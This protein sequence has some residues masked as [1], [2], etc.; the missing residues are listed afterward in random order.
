MGRWDALFFGGLTIFALFFGF[1]SI[2]KW[3]KNRNHWS[4]LVA[5]MLSFLAGLWV[6]LTGAFDLYLGTMSAAL[7][8][9]LLSGFFYHS[10]TS[11]QEGEGPDQKDQEIT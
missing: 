1:E 3:R 11:A 9:R 8:I 6:L 10:S 5:S 2:T 4:Y 7:V